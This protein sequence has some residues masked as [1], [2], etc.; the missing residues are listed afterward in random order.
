MAITERQ[1]VNGAGEEPQRTSQSRNSQ[2]RRTGRP[3]LRE[4]SERHEVA[5]AKGD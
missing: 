3:M 2:S 1:E 5:P 4:G